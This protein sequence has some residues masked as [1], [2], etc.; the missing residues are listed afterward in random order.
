MGFGWITMLF[1]AAFALH[2]EIHACRI[3]HP[4][5]TEQK[6]FELSVRPFGC[7]PPDAMLRRVKAIKP[8]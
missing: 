5:I 4:H 1:G 3:A 2:Q 7:V 6:A 8:K